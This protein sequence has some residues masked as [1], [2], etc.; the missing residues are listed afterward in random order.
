[1]IGGHTAPAATDEAYAAI[2]A[3]GIEYIILYPTN[4]V[5]AGNV[6]FYATPFQLA[7]KYGVKI[8]VYTNNLNYN[9]TDTVYNYAGKSFCEY[10]SETYPEVFGGVI[11]WDEPTAGTKAEMQ[12]IYEKIETFLESYTQICPGF[13]YYINLNPIYAN[14]DTQLG[15]ME[16]D[17]YVAYFSELLYK[18]TAQ[19]PLLW[20][21]IYPLYVSGT[22]MRSNWLKN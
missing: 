11:V 20:C 14:V 9:F 13:P 21:D 5:G 6:D 18:P 15:D 1:M 17:E 12:T 8:L 22:E 16:Y 4:A 2:A 10:W 19:T 7:K 3:A